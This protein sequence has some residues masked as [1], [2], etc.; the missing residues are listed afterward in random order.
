MSEPAAAT[1]DESVVDEEIDESKGPEAD[2]E[3]EYESDFKSD[4]PSPQRNKRF[5][6]GSRGAS[7]DISKEDDRDDDYD[8]NL[9]Q[10]VRPS[11]ELPSLRGIQPTSQLPSLRGAPRAGGLAPL[12]GL[13]AQ[14]SFFDTPG[15]GPTGDD[16]SEDEKSADVD[17]DDSSLRAM[18]GSGKVEEKKEDT[19]QSEVID[20][21][22]DDIEEAVNGDDDSN[23]DDYNDKGEE[24]SGGRDAPETTAYQPKRAN[25]PI[26][27]NKLVAVRGADGHESKTGDASF[28]DDEEDD[29]D[30]RG[31]ASVQ[32]L[33]VI[34]FID[35]RIK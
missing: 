11:T 29:D 6:F 21:I 2:D 17:V 27:P 33:K 30:G 14:K 26:Q 19:S 5:P 31:K 1:I 10:S 9:P 18:K 20:E 35:R 13:D 15:E 3:D 7:S 32:R 12:G 22:E 24:K 28:E 8:A 25:D 23:F 16:Y 4:S 34:I